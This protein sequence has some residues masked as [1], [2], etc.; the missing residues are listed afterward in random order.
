MACMRELLTNTMMDTCSFDSGM[1][2]HVSCMQIKKIQTQIL[3]SFIYLFCL[4]AM[5]VICAQRVIM[6]FGCEPW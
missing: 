6:L 4:L 2:R 1:Q 5:T 3:H